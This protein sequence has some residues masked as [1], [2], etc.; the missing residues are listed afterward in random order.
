MQ[1]T[2]SAF[3]HSILGNF[4]YSEKIQQIL[5]S[6]FLKNSMSGFNHYL[7]QSLFHNIHLASAEVILLAVGIIIFLGVL[8]E[9]FFRRTGI[10]DVAFLMVA[11]VII[12]PIFGIVS[13]ETVIKISPYFAA[14]ALIIIMFDGGLHLDVRS[15][16]KTA[17]FA[18]LLAIF[19]FAVS[20]VL[21]SIIAVYS[22]GWQWLDSILLG[23]MVGGSSSIIVFG[24]V[25]NLKISE[26]TKAMLSLE[27]AITDIIATV[28]AFLLFST[29]T[30]G[31]FNP[32][33]L[34]ITAAQS[35]S[36]GLI[37]GFGVGIP[38]MF[39]FSR[40]Q[41]ARHAYM[42]TL[43]ILFVLF[44]LA[45]SFGGTGA[46]TALIFG[47]MLGNRHLF[48]KHLKIKMPEV[49]TDNSFHDQLTFLVRTFFFVFMGL[50]AN[51][52]E[53]GYLVFG[54]AMAIAIY[55]GR[56]GVTKS[57]LTKRFS[58]FDKKIT[59]VMIPRGL[60]AAVLATVPLTLG[61]KNADAYPQI[62]FVIIIATVIITTI[63]LAKTRKN[64]P[65]VHTDK[66]NNQ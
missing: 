65:Q 56:V 39:I 37:L 3:F 24:L 64:Q 34:G 53:I 32:N 7:N 22:L 15:I 46:L 9:S 58:S 31:H 41:N 57:S 44:F 42:L 51:F 36:V 19:G 66:N 30:S 1:I 50:L 59:S 20:V 52:G 12:G 23:I 35:I 16:I 48:A 17:H 60:A 26:E 5:D 6:N 43:A 62:V 10:P 29:I 61:V 8:G 45:K 2:D 28:G 18:F 55:F 14:L 40:L 47:L 33:L 27:S 11:G 4:T 25:R 13:T 38:W 54:I 63:G 49:S 21:V